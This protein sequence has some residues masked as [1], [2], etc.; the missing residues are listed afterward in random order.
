MGGSFGALWL[1]WILWQALK[2]DEL[3]AALLPE[4]PEAVPWAHVVTILVIGRLCEP[5]SELHVGIDQTA[6][7]RYA[8]EEFTH[9]AVAATIAGGMANAGFGIRAAAVQYGLD[10]IPFA[11]ERYF[12]HAG[13]KCS[14]RRGFAPSSK[15]CGVRSSKSWSRTCPATTRH[16]PAKSPRSR[17]HYKRRKSIAATRF[18]GTHREYGKI[19]ASTI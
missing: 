2:L 10:F 15:F 8:S 12:W 4:K 9:L 16:T 14:I 6:I 5:S 3:L 18:I 7:S 11:T 17:R 13:Q 19:D 1:G